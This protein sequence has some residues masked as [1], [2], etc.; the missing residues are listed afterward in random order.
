MQG[1]H[2]LTAGKSCRRLRLRIGV[3]RGEHGVT[4][5]ERAEVLI[6]EDV[7]QVDNGGILPVQGAGLLK[8]YGIV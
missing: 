5:G 1:G 8:I 4:F 6:H 2:G 7:L 3:R